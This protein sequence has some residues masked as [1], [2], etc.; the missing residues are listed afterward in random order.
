MIITELV[1]AL[2]KD[3]SSLEQTRPHMTNKTT[4]AAMTK[5]VNI[6]STQSPTRSGG[7]DKSYPTIT[8]PNTTGVDPN[9]HGMCN[10]PPKVVTFVFL[11]LTL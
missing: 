1:S 10:F 7:Y 6:S 9:Q 4:D 3:K 5:P 2:V 8:Q 11:I